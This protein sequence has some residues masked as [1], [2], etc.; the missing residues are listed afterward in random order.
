MPNLV[1]K[2]LDI[3]KDEGLDIVF[4]KII[5][6]FDRMRKMGVIYCKIIN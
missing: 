5:K 1:A 4:Y 6:K 2:A 3:L